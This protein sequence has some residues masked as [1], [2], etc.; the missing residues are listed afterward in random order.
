MNVDIRLSYNFF[1][2]PIGSFDGENSNSRLH[3]VEDATTMQS[4]EE[5]GDSK[6]EIRG[7][8]TG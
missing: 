8:H 5:F 3:S 2:L 4:T 6:I 1:L 7:F